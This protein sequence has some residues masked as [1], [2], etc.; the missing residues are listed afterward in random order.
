[1][2]YTDKVL[3]LTFKTSFNFYKK[4][5]DTDT[6]SAIKANADVNALVKKMK[7]CKSNH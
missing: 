4:L 6:R 7:D 5:G 2:S 3:A 1:M